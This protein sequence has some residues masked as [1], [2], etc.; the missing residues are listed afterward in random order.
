MSTQKPGSLVGPTITTWVGIKEKGNRLE[1]Q[2][3]TF[4]IIT[5]ARVQINFFDI[6][7]GK[8]YWILGCGKDKEMLLLTPIG[9]NREINE[10]TLEECRT[11]IHRLPEN[12]EKIHSVLLA[13][14]K[15]GTKELSWFNQA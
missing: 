14:T 1:C 15:N 6:M 7:T 3:P 5:W 8:E 13:N 12:L 10:H 2:K 11:N 4:L 9:T